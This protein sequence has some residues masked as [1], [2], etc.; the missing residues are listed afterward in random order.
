[1]KAFIGITMAV[2]LTVSAAA[3]SAAVAADDRMT[4][5]RKLANDSMQAFEAHETP[6]A[7]KIAKKLEKAWDKG[8]KE[9]KKKKQGPRGAW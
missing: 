6:T 1:M 4:P 9:L 2:A 5:Y 8:E 3:A 7:K